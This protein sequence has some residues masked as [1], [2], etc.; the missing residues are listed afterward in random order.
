MSHDEVTD[1]APSRG[2]L[3]RRAVKLPPYRLEAPEENLELLP[4]VEGMVT[5]FFPGGATVH[6]QG[7]V[8][9]CGIAKTFRAPEGTSALAVGDGVTVA[10]VQQ[11]HRSDS[12]AGDKV[13]A[14]GMILAR[15][16]RSS[17]L[18]RPQ[19][20]SAKR[21]KKYQTAWAEKVI[22]ANID[23]LL[24]VMSVRQPPLRAAVVDRFLIVA[25]RGELAPLLVINKIDLGS[26]DESTVAGFVDL[27]VKVVL[28]SA[29]TGA[30]LDDLRAALAGRRS[31][32]A[33]ASGVGK[34][35][36]VNA[37]VPGATAAVRSVRVKDQRGRHTTGATC[38]YELAGDARGGVI[39]D[40]PGVRELGIELTAA[41][42]PWYFPEFDEHSPRCHFSNCT[43]THEPDCAVL[44]AVEAG[45]ISARRYESY[46]RILGT[47][48][49]T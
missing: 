8:L 27:G 36:L 21:V 29:V 28:C 23:Q 22:V 32:L 2:R 1:K 26:P 9:L 31:V 16:P 4:N 13:R 18:V 5:G 48:T 7:N 47:L 42:L 17:A 19:P 37:L 33:G 12:A 10:V 41:E 14:D 46:L 34:S 15:Q 11:E 3:A 35:T 30:G 20:R 44:A 45:T 49:K 43:H 24:I 40:T 39:V 25:E 38:I 6:V